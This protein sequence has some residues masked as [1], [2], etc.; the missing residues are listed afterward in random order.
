[1]ELDWMILQFDSIKWVYLYWHI[2]HLIVGF[3]N[4]AIL[5]LMM[6]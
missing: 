6:L 3:S 5:S 1:M 4:N 2:K